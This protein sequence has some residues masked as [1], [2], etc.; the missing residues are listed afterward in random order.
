MAFTRF[1]DI[2]GWQLARVLAQE[3]YKVTMSGSFAR[4]F[5]LCDQVNRASGSAMDNIAEGFDGGSNKEFVRFLSYA[6][7]SCSE[8]QSQLYR[9]LERTHIN[10]EQFDTLYEQAAH[11]RSKIGG[12]IRYLKK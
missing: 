11:A 12:L 3:V 4:D 10:Q 8:V 1:E 7:R 9:A 6:Q 5:S 2:E